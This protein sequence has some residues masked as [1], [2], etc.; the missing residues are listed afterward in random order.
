MA[1]VINVVNH[2]TQE[3]AAVSD[4]RSAVVHVETRLLLWMMQTPS[5]VAVAAGRNAAADAVVRDDAVAV[6]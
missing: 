2:G 6:G 4:A 3:A 1:A 5:T